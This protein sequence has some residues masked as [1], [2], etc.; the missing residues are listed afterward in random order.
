MKLGKSPRPAPRKT[1]EGSVRLIGGRWR[2]TRL[3]VLD[4]DGL[5]PSSDRVRETVFNWLQFEL[6]GL[7]VLDAFAGSG[8]LGLE[9]ASRGAAQVFLVERDPRVAAGLQSS[10]QQ[11]GAEQVQVIQADVLAWLAQH[12]ALQFDLAFVDPP[13][14]A[15]LYEP[16]LRALAP[17][18]GAGAWLYVEL[19][20]S[21][22]LPALPGWRC[23]R[24]GE[25]REVRFMLYRREPADSTDCA[26]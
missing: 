3:P 21:L 2:G 26:P 18:L 19:P 14:A 15:G 24:Q 13:F 11:L 16:V 1:P 12:P 6:H 20:L 9:A 4:A 17:H 10:C 8:A 5:R 23:H 22:D 7:R 25:T